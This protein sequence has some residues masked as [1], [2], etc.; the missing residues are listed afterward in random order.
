M[1]DT[2]RSNIPQRKEEAFILRLTASHLHEGWFDLGGGRYVADDHLN[3]LAENVGI[4]FFDDGIPSN[5]EGEDWNYAVTGLLTETGATRPMTVAGLDRLAEVL[6]RGRETPRLDVDR[7]KREA[8]A[9]STET[10][11]GTACLQILGDG[12]SLDANP[13]FNLS[14]YAVPDYGICEM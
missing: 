8:M 14:G 13:A 1:L 6:N 3:N 2:T 7:V 9:M 11:A 10:G 12:Q 5:F 4:D